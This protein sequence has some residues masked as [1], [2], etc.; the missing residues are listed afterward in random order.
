[1]DIQVG[2]AILEDAIHEFVDFALKRMVRYV[3]RSRHRC[4]DSDG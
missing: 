2:L 3:G 1:M 4:L